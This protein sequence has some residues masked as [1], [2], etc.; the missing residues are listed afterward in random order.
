MGEECG[1]FQAVVVVV[2]VGGSEDT[3]DMMSE[4]YHTA[5]S[6]ITD[7]PGRFFR[8]QDPYQYQKALSKSHTTQIR[9]IHQFPTYLDIQLP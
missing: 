9:L 8:A 1:G 5:W 7:L 2:V 3:L 6:I 4:E